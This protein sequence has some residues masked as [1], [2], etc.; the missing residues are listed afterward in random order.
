[1]SDSKQLVEAINEEYQAQLLLFAWHKLNIPFARKTEIL[2][3]SESSFKV[4]TSFAKGLFGSAAK[5]REDTYTFTEIDVSKEM[6]LQ[7]RVISVL[8]QYSICQLPPHS[9]HSIN[10]WLICALVISPVSNPLL[11]TIKSLL[12]NVFQKEIYGYYVLYTVCFL[13]FLETLF[14]QLI[15]LS[16]VK[17]PF[18]ARLSW[19]FWNFIVGL[20]VSEREYWL[21]KV[22]SK[23]KS[24]KN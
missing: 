9:I 14:S 2:E 15:F 6:N 24:K 1:M 10:I 12:M 22:A 11:V 16:S 8:K 13:H 20:Q 21:Y 17:M 7:R 19:L 4:S 18:F 5:S 3:L 23:S